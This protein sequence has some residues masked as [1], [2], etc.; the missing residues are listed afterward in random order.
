LNK[1]S[2]QF[3]PKIFDRVLFNVLNGQWISTHSQVEMKMSSLSWEPNVL[4]SSHSPKPLQKRSWK[5]IP[6]SSEAKS[7]LTLCG[8]TID[9]PWLELWKSPKPLEWKSQLCINRDL[10]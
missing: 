10:N 6:K 1:T 8:N 5:R 9:K 7:C 2:S 4:N 3:F